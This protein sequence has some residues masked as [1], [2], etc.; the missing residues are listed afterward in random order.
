MISLTNQTLMIYIELSVQLILIYLHKLF[1]F[2]GSKVKQSYLDF[3]IR[4]VKRSI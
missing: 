1:H 2:H 4:L 3:R